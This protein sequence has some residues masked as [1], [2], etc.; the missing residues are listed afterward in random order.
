MR[1]V[2]WELNCQNKWV[3]K[4]NGWVQ[5]CPHLVSPRWWPLQTGN[6]YQ[7]SDHLISC[8]LVITRHRDQVRWTFCLLPLGI[9]LCTVKWALLDVVLVRWVHEF[10][11]EK[12]SKKNLTL[13][14]TFSTSSEGNVLQTIIWIPSSKNIN[15]LKFYFFIL[16][17]C[18]SQE[19]SGYF[20]NWIK[21]LIMY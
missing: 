13:G 16:S 11:P 17:T 5:Q 6:V 8:A 15:I 21:I 20:K 12:I 10:L 3:Q 19:A 7:V 4:A 9:S 14:F 2:E 18:H 1:R